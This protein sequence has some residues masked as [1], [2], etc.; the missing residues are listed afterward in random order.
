MLHPLST[1][2]AYWNYKTFTVTWIVGDSQIEEVYEYGDWPYFTGSTNKEADGC[3]SY[4]FTGWDKE[5]DYVYGDVT[6]TAQYE[7]GYSH[8]GEK[9]YTY[10][11]ENYHKVACSSCGMVLNEAE[12]HKDNAG[13]CPCGK[14]ASD[15]VAT[16]SKNGVMTGAYTSVDDAI[17]AVRS[18]TAADE[19]VVT[20][21]KDIDLG[22]GDLSIYSGVFTIDLNGHEISSTSADWGALYISG[23]SAHVTIQGAGENSK[24]TGSDTGII[25]FGATLTSSSASLSSSSSSLL[26]LQKWDFFSS[27]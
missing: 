19:A 2:D 6:Y 16:V 24:I 22:D 13:Y 10:V 27:F 5:I 11:D 12:E 17:Q 26:R 25:I 21:Q 7:T 4:T 14:M 23:A 3:I 9:K 15:V 20:L 18:C 8:I 1:N